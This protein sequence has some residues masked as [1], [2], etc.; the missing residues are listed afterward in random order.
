MR[1]RPET[2]ED[3]AATRALQLAAF[4]P[5]TLEA[6]IVDRLRANGDLVLS[7]VAT[8]GDAIVGHIVLSKAH[9]EQH[10]ALGLGPIGVLPDRR[11]EG[12]GAALMDDAIRRA[13]ETDYPLIALLGHPSYY[14]RFGFEPAKAKY[15]ITTLYEAP[16]EAWMALALPAYTPQVRGRFSYS[17]AFG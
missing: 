17:D 1:I 3:E 16:P 13:G 2:P 15:G 10:A 4:A 8:D 5:S 7:L 6:E 9:V 11:R 14:P 12:I